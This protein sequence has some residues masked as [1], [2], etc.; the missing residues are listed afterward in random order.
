MRI[1]IITIGTRGDVQP[2]IALGQGLI[3]AGHT[4]RLATHK[5]FEDLV[6]S[7]GLEF[8]SI[9][10]NAQLLAGN[11]EVRELSEKGNFVATLRRMQKSGE[12][13]ISG[14]MEDGYIASQEMDLLISGTVGLIAASSIAEKNQIPLLHAHVFPTTPTRDFPSILIPPTFPNLGRTFNLLSSQLVMH[15]GWMGARPMLN[16]ARKNTFDLP[17]ASLNGIAATSPLKGFPA[18]YG[19]SPSVIPKPADWRA[20]DHITGYWFLD[21]PDGWTPPP[22]LLNFLRTGPPPL[23]I[24]FGSIGNRNPEETTELVLQALEKTQQ[25]AILLSGW[26]GLQKMD[27]PASIFMLDS[28]T[29]T[30]LFSQ[31][32]AVIHH[33]GAGTTSAGLRAGVPSIVIPFLGDQYFWGRRV[34]DLGVGPAPIPRSKLTVDRLAQAINEAV[35]NTTMRQRA[36]KLGAKIQ[37]EDGIANAVKII[38][39]I[40]RIIT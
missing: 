16:R 31:V 29:F 26:G 34:Q 15:L 25:R 7:Y 12:H 40:E 24:G 23:Y 2:Y 27:F 35:T 30:W 21:P 10:G 33:G 3:K 9:R 8:W 4:V 6:K 20:E 22:D 17:P 28:I 14:W 11:Q 19:F 5:D 18:I 38:G 32:A 1:A 37:A 39:Q 36:A 13:A